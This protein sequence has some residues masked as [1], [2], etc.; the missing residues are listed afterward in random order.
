MISERKAPISEKQPY[1]QDSLD[2]FLSLQQ[3]ELSVRTQE[4]ELKKQSDI[5]NYNYATEALKENAK[6]LQETRDHW[7]FI[8]Q[9]TWVLVG[10][11][12]LLF[13]IF[14]MTALFLG[15]SEIISEILKAILYIVGGGTTGSSITSYFYRKNQKSS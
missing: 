4:F 13:F 12:F 7:K 2:K 8:I 14:M 6:H 10:G 5:H 11:A 9:K 15:E 3:Q 1:S